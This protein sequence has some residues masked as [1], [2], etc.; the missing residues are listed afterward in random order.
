MATPTDTQIWTQ[1][2]EYCEWL[3][4]YE[5]AAAA[6]TVTN[7]DAIVSAF[8]GDFI[9]GIQQV[10]AAGRADIARP[11]TKERIAAGFR[12]FLQDFAKVYN[13]DVDP[14]TASNADL[15]RLLR[16]QMTDDSDTLNSNEHTIDSSFSSG[17]TTGTG[18]IVRLT[19]DK[20]G[21]ELAGLL[22]GG[23]QTFTVIRDARGGRGGRA[24]EHA[25][26]FEYQAEPKDLD[27]LTWTGTGIRQTFASA[28]AADSTPYVKNPSFESNDAG[29]T[30]DST[31]GSTTAVTN[32]TLSA[33]ASFRLRT[34]GS[35][36]SGTLTYR[37]YPGDG[38]GYL[39]ALECVAN[40]ATASQ[41]LQDVSPGIE[42][43]DDVPYYCQTAV[44]RQDSGDGNARLRFGASTATT[45]VT[46]ATTWTR[47][48]IAVG[49]GCWYQNFNEANMDVLLGLESNTTG[50]VIFDDVIVK[51]FTWVEGL[52]WIC[53]VGGGT[54]W[55]FGDTLTLT[56]AF[57]STR[58]RIDY[59][60]AR[61]FYDLVPQIR[62]WFPTAT[63]AAET[64][65]AGN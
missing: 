21:N 60:L 22:P 29:T 40:N 24:R 1:L 63:G 18:T 28:N 47:L 31:P 55:I 49:T 27:A 11:L 53:A 8:N 4:D 14:A 25:E 30:D 34:D 44:I 3:N 37:G 15:L 62:G 6:L 48:P 57:G 23:T 5:V 41:V 61:A 32:W 26:V 42:F 10:L 65:D 52:G 64:I 13:W 20:D 54:P 12:P 38:N 33:A 59:W 39:W 50:S 35:G 19:V 46:S 43:R 51:P 36:S 7:Y 45:S 56:D 2:I 17:G 9:P 58:A 16:Q